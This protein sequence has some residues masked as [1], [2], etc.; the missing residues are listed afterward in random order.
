MIGFHHL[1]CDNADHPEVPGWIAEH[2]GRRW[3]TIVLLGNALMHSRFHGLLQSAPL[4]VHR[5][6]ELGETLCLVG[7][8]S[9]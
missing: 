6:E 4:L 9:R 3:T 2:D 8:V 1:R 5:I 7:I